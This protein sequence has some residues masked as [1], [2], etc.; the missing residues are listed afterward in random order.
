MKRTALILGL[1]VIIG[2]LSWAGQK[3]GDDIAVGKYRKLVSK[4]TNEERTLLVW[5][6]RS[7][8]ESSLRYP[9]LYLLYGQNLS[10]YMLPAITAC[11]LLSASG[12]APEMIIVG[13]ATAERY[14]DYSSIADGTIENTVRFFRD[15]LF[16]FVDSQ[17]R[18]KGFRI[19]VGPQAGAVFSFYALLKHPDLFHAYVLENPFVWQ[20][21]E[22]L[23]EMAKNRL[24]ESVPLN[25]FLFI[26]EEKSRNPLFVQTA[27]QFAETVKA[28][29][30]RD[31]RFHF[32][33]VEPSGYFVPPAPV[34][35]GLQK[36][37]EP[38]V[39]P[40]DMK[41]QGLQDILA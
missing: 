26:Q 22:I 33:L 8:Q 38:F 5:L 6:P 4:I 27:G 28:G 34:K 18:T 13:V 11:D 19:V 16:P 10:A 39:F 35:E 24:K 23:F 9:V 32:S 2:A 20:N 14:R 36:L 12:A 21:R 25:R 41:V 15:E 37:F 1:L 7:Y 40:G 30:P 17:Y 3:E 29:A 31:F